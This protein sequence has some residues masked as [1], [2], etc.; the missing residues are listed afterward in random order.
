[1]KHTP[2]KKAVAS[3]KAR[4]A[5]ASALAQIDGDNGR[6]L[7]VST[8]GPLTKQVGTLGS[9]NERG[10]HVNVNRAINKVVRV[11]AGQRRVLAAPKLALTITAQTVATAA[12]SGAHDHKDGY[13]R[14]ALGM[15]RRQDALVVLG[16]A[17]MDALEGGCHG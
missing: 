7:F 1:M 2:L 14:M 16:G 13:A 6:T 12:M 10:A 4:A 3:L 17:G 15:G 5:R 11:E 9:T 8:H